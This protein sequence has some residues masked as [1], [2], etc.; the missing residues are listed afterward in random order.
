MVD[1][2]QSDVLDGV[3]FSQVGFYREEKAQELPVSTYPDT[4]VNPCSISGKKT[5]QLKEK[6]R[7]KER[8][9]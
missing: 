3:D 8:S 2:P 9:C 4:L 5:Q 6:E 7:K 1:G